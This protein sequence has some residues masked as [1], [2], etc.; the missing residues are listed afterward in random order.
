MFTIFNYVLENRFAL[1]YFYD[2]H[3]FLDLS[4]MFIQMAAELNITFIQ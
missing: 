4:R 1:H 3:S 2:L